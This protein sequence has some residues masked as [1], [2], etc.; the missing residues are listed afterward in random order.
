M[1]DRDVLLRQVFD[2]IE[3]YAVIVMDLEGRVVDCNS[4]VERLFGFQRGELLGRDSGVIFVPEDRLAGIPDQEMNGALE[5]GSARDDRWHLRKDGSRVWVNGIMSVVKDDAGSD[6]GFVKIVRDRTEDRRLQLALEES[7]ARYRSLLDDV[8][9]T[10]TVGVVIL[11][12]GDEVVW[13]N[14]AIEDYLGVS[15]HEVMGSNVGDV[16][17]QTFTR[18]AAEA[19][20]A[21]EA[22]EGS[23]DEETEGR[24]LEIRLSPK[25]GK[26]ERWLEY[27]RLPIDSGPFAGGHIEHYY[28]ITNL[29]LAQKQLAEARDRL[30]AQVEERTADLISLNKELESFN[31]SVSH[32]LRAPLRGLTG[33][34][35]ILLE[36]YGERL[37]EQGRQYLRRVDAAA[38]RMGQLIDALLALSRASRGELQWQ[39]VELSEMV[40]TILRALAE[41][42]PGRRVDVEIEADLVAFA[43]PR[44]LRLAL[45]NLLENAWKFT[46]NREQARIEF[47]R[48]S[49]EQGEA[50]FVRDN[51]A[52]F[53]MRYADKLFVPF[54]RLHSPQQFGGMGIGLATVQ[55]IVHR[56]GGKVWAQGARDKGATFYFT[57]G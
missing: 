33:F 2:S 32:D 16:F 34:S 45:E 42:E 43:D 26:D 19:A 21:T 30:E 49:T 5:S 46:A 25:D 50:Y 9:D 7:E 20:R 13:L 15:R 22:P 29:K 31:Y 37:D 3:E 11:D 41:R 40:T 47:G 48:A 53:E 27:R 18:A 8:L 14:R 51:G 23:H 35:Q 24:R 52:G 56:H 17:E 6:R 38:E 12:S 54:Q 10:S 36:D 44:L 39:R 1:S 55:R 4:G 28:D 57:L